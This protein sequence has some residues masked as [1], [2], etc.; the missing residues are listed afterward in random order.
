MVDNSPT[1]ET[2]T[3]NLSRETLEWNAACL[4]SVRPHCNVSPDTQRWNRA[5]LDYSLNDKD[6]S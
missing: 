1:Y 6:K 3:R 5:C 2:A 4:E